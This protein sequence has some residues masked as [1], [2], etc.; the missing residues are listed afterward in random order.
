MMRSTKILALGLAALAFV[1]CESRTDKVDGG[2]VLLSISDF[3]GLPTSVNIS[4]VGDSLRIPSLTV[5]N[6]VK[7]TS[8]PT[9]DLM[10]VEIQY[11]EVTFTRNDTGT[12]IPQPLVE[13]RPAV[14]PVNGSFT[15]GNLPVMR[16]AQLDYPA[17]HDLAT[18]GVDRETNSTTVVLN[19]WL[20]F[21]G[22][23]LS[24]D[25]IDTG[26][27]RGFTVQFLP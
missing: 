21:Y 3:Q 12:R 10:N 14:V 9:S 20:R 5:Q 13:S 1:G 6:I 26:T 25:P 15:Y 22:R 7:N 8:Q 24:G 23:T 27:G 16:L 11:F 4:G 2:G 19:L 17:L 18:F